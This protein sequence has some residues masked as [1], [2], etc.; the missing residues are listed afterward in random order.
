MAPGSDPVVGAR[1]GR[2]FR[3]WAAVTMGCH[4]ELEGRTSHMSHD[5][6]A[7]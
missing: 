3:A 2:Q 5:Q 7:R 1:A 6:G 4:G